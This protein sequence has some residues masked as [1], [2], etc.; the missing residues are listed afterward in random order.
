MK[1]N[2]IEDDEDFISRAKAK[3]FE[4]SNLPQN[5]KNEESY[6]NETLVDTI[7]DG[8]YSIS[9]IDKKDNNIKHKYFYEFFI[10]L[11]LFINS[12]ISYSLTNIL[13][14]CYSFY[15]FYNAYST[16]YSFRIMLKQYLAILIIMVDSLYLFLKLIIHFYIISKKGAMTIDKD[17]KENILVITEN[18]RTIYDYIV[19]CLIIIMLMVN[20]IIKNYN[21]EYYNNNELL[22]NIRIIERNLKYNNS[23]INLGTLLLCFG[24]AICPSL[25]NLFILI[26][27]LI[28]FYSQT[29]NRNLKSFI[30]KYIKYIF[31][32]II[33]LYTIYNYIFSS[34]F[35]QQK[36]MNYKNQSEIPYYLGIINLF[37]KEDNNNKNQYSNI[38]GLFNFLLFYSSFYF[39][40]LHKKCLDYIKNTQENRISINTSYMNEKDINALIQLKDNEEV[41]MDEGELLNTKTISL[42]R[43]FLINKEKN[44]MQV[45]ID[46]DLDC[47]IIFF[48]KETKDLNFFQKIKLFICKFCYSPGFVLHACRIGVIFWINFFNIYYDSYFII[49]WLSLSIKYSKNKYFLY[50]T[51]YLF[52]P[53][54]VSIFFISY[55]I[56][57]KG[58]QKFFKLNPQETDL[59]KAIE[60]TSKLIVLYIFQ[61]FIHLNNRHLNKLKDHEINNDIKKQLKDIEKKIE[62]DFKGK[63]VVKPLE[64]LFKIYFLLIDILIV[65]FFYLSFSQK[66]NLFNLVV[67]I[68]IIAFLI[69]NK[70]FKKIIYICL[71]V[72]TI[73][74]LLKYTLYIYKLD[75]NKRFKL[76]IDILFNDDLEKIYYYWIS[77]Y[78]LFL[79]YIGQTSK[80]FKLC[81]SKRFYM[82]EI[83]EYNLAS[84][85]YVKF[86]L[87]TLFN[88]IF[89][90]Y[91][92]LLIPCFLFCLLIYDNNCLSLF[93]LTIVF[94]IY[95]KYIRIVNSKFKRKQNIYLYTKILIYTNIFNFIVEYIIQF[96]NNPY[97]IVYFHFYYPEKKNRTKIE[98]FGFFLFKSNYTTNLLSFYMRFILSLALHNE[99]QRQHDINTK[100]SIK[101]TELVEYYF[102]NSI[103]KFAALRNELENSDMKI[104]E[105]KNNDNS[106]NNLTYD[107]AYQQKLKKF[108]KKIKENQK[109]KKIVRNLFNIL[110][111]FLHYYWIVIFILVAILS[112]HWMLSISMVIQLSIFSFYMAKSFNGY[113]KC[114]KGQNYIN[115][116]GVKIYKKLTLNQKLKLYKEEKKQH[117]KIT[118]QIQ[119]EYFSL[120]WIFTFTFIILSYLNS[121]IIKYLSIYE[122]NEN[123]KNFISALAYLLGVYSEPKSEENNYNFWSYTWGYFIIIGLF[124]IR[125]YF[126][127]KFSEIKIMYFNEEKQNKQ[128]SL[129]TSRSASQSSK[130]SRQSKYLEDVLIDHINK[131]DNNEI[132]NNNSFDL[133]G[134][135][136][137]NIDYFDN[138]N[139]D[140]LFNYDKCN[141]SMKNLNNIY[142][143]KKNEYQ[144]FL[145]INYNSKKNDN[146]LFIKEDIEERKLSKRF[147][148][149]YFKQEYIEYIIEERRFH[150][151]QDDININYRKNIINKNFENIIIFQIRLKKLIELLIIILLLINALLK[152]NIL[153][154]VFL[155]ILIPTYKLQLVNT[156][157]MFKISFVVL[158]LLVIQ[159]IV[160][161]SN[162]SYITNP[163]INNEI[164]LNVNQLF[165]IPWYKDYRWS[166]FYS[167]GTNR[168][169]IISI[170]LD[171]VIILI[172]YFYLEYFSFTIFREEDR[173]LDLKIIS[174]K[175]Y[176]KFNAL[177]ALSKNEFKSF[178]RAMK[179]SY[180]IELVPSFISEIDRKVEQY[181]YK[182]YNKDA[183]RLLYLFKEDKSIF[184]VD[185]NSKTKRIIKIRGFIY[186]SFQYLFLILT[187]L[188][189]S[190]NQG[191][192]GFG[193]MSF[194]IFYIYKSHCFL[195]GRRWTLLNGIH[196]F[197]KPFLFFDILTQFIFQIPLD[198]YKKNKLKL[199]Y[200][201][202]YFGY[203]QIADYS[204]PTDFISGVSCFIVIMKILC[205]F[206]LLIQE[207]MY[208]SYD[209]KKF[210]LKYHYEYLQKAFVKGKLH[211]FLFNNHRV[212]LMND[213]NKEN[214]RVQQNLLNIEKTVNNWNIKITS[215]NSN[216]NSDNK[217]NMYEIPNNQNMLSKKDKG[218]T[219]SKILRKHWLISLTMRIL[220]ASNSI[221]D[222]H[223]N[224][225]GYILKILKGHFILYSDLDN[226]INEY[227]NNNF[228]K[229]NDIKKIKKLLGNYY[230][231]INKKNKKKELIKS[232]HDLLSSLNYNRRKSSLI[233]PIY[234]NNLVKLN[235][236][237]EN[238]NGSIKDEYNF[239]QELKRID[240]NNNESNTEEDERGAKVDN[241]KNSIQNININIGLKE[242]NEDSNKH[243]DKNKYIKL[244]QQY[245][246]MF[247]SDSDYRD[248]KSLIRED[249]F[250]TYCTR[251]KLF[252]LLL[253]SIYK[254]FSENNEYIIYFFLLMN[255]LING[256][257][258]SLIYPVLILLFGIIQYPRPS[259]LFWKILMIYTTFLIFIKFIIQLNMWEM[260]KYTKTVIGFFDESNEKYISY[261]GIK[262]IANHDFYLFISYIILDFIVLLLLIIN[263]AILIRKGLWYI[264]ETDYETIEEANDRI[265]IY[266]SKKMCDKIGFDEDN[267]KVL[268][269]NEILKLIG[270]VKEEKRYGI[271]QRLQIFH[272]RNFTKLRNEKPGKDFYNYYTIIQ[273][274]ILIYIIFFYTKMERDSIIYNAD[275]FK[276]KQFSG[277]MV[278]FAFIHVFIIVFDRFLYLKNIRKLKQISFKV[279]D[280]K[281]GEDVTFKFK[282]YTF[283]NTLE[284][285]EK[286]KNKHDYEVISFQLEGTQLGLLLKYITQIILVIFIHIFVYFY[287]PTKD[288]TNSN[289]NKF[290]NKVTTNIFTFIF[291]VLYIF[292]FIFSGL[293]I[294]YGLTDMR[295]VSSLM[296]A[297]NLLYNITY[298]IYKQIPFLFE[299]KNFIDW[300]FTSTALDLWKWLKL[301]EIISLLYIN[302]C[303]SKGNM[304]RRVGTL[305]PNYMKLMMGGTTYFAIIILIFGPL[306]LF[307]S[308]NPINI[309][310][311]VNGVNL[312]IVLCMTIENS[313]RINLTLFR[314][315][316]SIIKGFNSEEEY[317]DYLVAQ[318]NSELSNFN[319]SYKYQQVQKV[320]LIGFSEHKW[321]ISYQLLNYLKNINYTN[322]EY[323]LSLIYS[324]TTIANTE[325]D[326]NFKYEKLF[327]INKETLANLS[328]AFNSKNSSQAYLSLSEFYYP[329]QRIMEDNMPNPL[330]TNI[331]KDAIL[332]MEKTKIKNKNRFIYNWHLKEANN[333]D[334]EEDL[335]NFDGIEFLTFTDLFSRATFGYDVITFYITFILVSGQLIRAIFMGQAQRIIYSEMV[336]P[337]KLFSVC[338]GIKLSR[339]RKN[340]LQEEKLYYLLIDMMRSPE[341]IK[342]ITQSSL[343][344][345]QESNI[346]KKEAKRMEFE[347]ESNPIVKKKIN[348]SFI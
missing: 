70:N 208:S 149:K 56:N 141:K 302:K 222:E 182:P 139:N 268:S 59:K 245:D 75:E 4:I 243:I 297:S 76:I 143:N 7:M 261:L 199:E 135:D 198:K 6:L 9:N 239:N 131:I 20:V 133:S 218:I 220:E 153:S 156:H 23:M 187:L 126:M 25:I 339:I 142:Y 155:I 53:F 121:I 83:F 295:K 79:E 186:I 325:K 107:K 303:I 319:K 132:D 77:Y 10:S 282:K 44:K 217:Y 34:V 146:E 61:M 147:K 170:W 229:Y 191:L 214:I 152:C 224:V 289:N 310:N 291:Y 22:P 228:E 293:Q 171:V 300:T 223:F 266:N 326:S 329:F 240:S 232:N 148:E 262:K 288:L 17:I 18:W 128:N 90:V 313:T 256:N 35:I 165:N 169:Q 62:Q 287:L 46:S 98:L 21:C 134:Y 52:Y 144:E 277:N 337:N 345:I 13:H 41:D 334:I 58:E 197:L 123:I 118:S 27:G 305:T 158:I 247:F 120:I 314:T 91:I 125:A 336:N 215:Y 51:K 185:K 344:Y 30:K 109:T 124:S 194:S 140:K 267:I 184:K 193:Y 253:K 32:S 72:L 335:N 100:D 50:F 210:I 320:K 105:V 231:K 181:L 168:Y 136:N 219:I 331:K 110:Y 304:K 270:N 39:I 196:Y 178:I 73:S 145:D 80:L 275:A 307:S 254:Y 249:F 292:Y 99:I 8:E 238:L 338:E 284:Y 49:I 341:I 88:F 233:M 318:N 242:K 323:Y 5:D 278:I 263:Q 175:Y 301:E 164:I 236:I 209:F 298:K 162:I 190:F 129:R 42:T 160:F 66:I 340:Y 312:K 69:M 317:S 258:L 316:N 103:N 82:N 47:G 96:M 1:E 213:R 172:L 188:I 93:Q 299:L 114:L 226:F 127:S 235:L 244:D 92:W 108:E 37:K 68:N 138:E 3:T 347:V 308:L 159:Y 206:L 31:L 309:I 311:S 154:L 54:L 111:Y 119:H 33:I 45:L 16:I 212:R 205:Y 346:V 274:I 29:L 89:G 179:V 2:I 202:K 280:K 74:F 227:E 85:T 290:E 84:Y 60:M 315:S 151:S 333:I 87:N 269:S 166:T 203:V 157:L 101:K 259:K 264:I 81:K 234:N 200:F 306:I 321:D 241:K 221:D 65:I 322:G 19:T 24:S 97:Y 64:V 117:F 40:N 255:H 176:K 26:L 283:D 57:I 55:S 342:N 189:S 324:F 63:Y 327:S 163:F 286:N 332:I 204:S 192:I 328:K 122:S 48:L 265:I 257:M 104:N 260:L 195:K 250:N 71:W 67:L 78:L 113:Y 251:K 112:I 248:L 106:K 161:T 201:F 102:V 15:I 281:T 167:F 150:Y 348:K 86:I 183:L 116:N 43:S 296:K 252:L 11:F 343:L 180:N 38:Y 115:K 272:K 271:I 279:L 276:L 285:I 273:V 174:K 246:D 225:A 207:N 137:I 216:N 14:L 211:S 130:S 230:M 330:V 177:K 95:Y 28:F 94:I 294:K 36:Y 173:T 12:F 237:D